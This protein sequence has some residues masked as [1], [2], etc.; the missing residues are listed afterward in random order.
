MKR[1]PSA[2]HEG[3]AQIKLWLTTHGI[4][5]FPWLAHIPDLNPIEHV[6]KISKDNINIMFLDLISMIRNEENRDYFET[7]VR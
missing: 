7:C 3:Y 1:D 6:W 5:M 4:E 2:K